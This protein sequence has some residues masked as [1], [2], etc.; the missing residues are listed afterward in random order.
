MGYAGVEVKLTI[1]QYGHG[2]M[3]SPAKPKLIE[4]LDVS[5]AFESYLISDG[6]DHCANGPDGSRMYMRG[7]TGISYEVH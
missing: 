4:E 6:W 5:E 2:T 7:D 3:S 1:W